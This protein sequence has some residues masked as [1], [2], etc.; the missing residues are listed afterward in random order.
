MTEL[1]KIISQPKLRKPTM[2]VGWET[3]TAQLGTRVTDFLIK[4]LD[5]QPF[6]DIAPEEFFPLGGVTI[7]NDIVQFPQSTFYACREHNLI[8][9]RSVQPRYEWHRFLSLIID[10]AQDFYRVKEMYAVG[11][12]IIMAA[13]TVPR[14]TWATF[15]TTQFKKTLSSSQLFR[16]MEFETPPGSRPTLNSYL[17][18]IA[19]TRKLTAA[20]LW[21]PVPFYLAGHDDYYAHKQVLEFFDKRL[22]LNLDYDTI[23]TSIKQQHDKLAR[24]RQSS[25]EIDGYLRKLENNQGLA[26]EERGALVKAVDESL[27]KRM[28]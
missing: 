25:A 21:V 23:D 5:A 28:K 15:S 24:L 6:A 22:K 19:K 18:W 7:E 14:E 17:L 16:E 2:I 8:I 27:R 20:N 26:E 4:N 11:G 3:D 9:F 10:I 12:M 13:H 1:L